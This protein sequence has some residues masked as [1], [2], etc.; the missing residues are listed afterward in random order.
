MTKARGRRRRTAEHDAVFG[1]RFF[2]EA[3]PAMV[4]SCP[5]PEGSDVACLLYLVDGAMLDVVQ[6]LALTERFCV[7]AVLEGEGDDGIERT[8]DDVGMAAVPYEIV[9]RASIRPL[10]RK[11]PFG[12]RLEETPPVEAV[13]AVE[14]V[15]ARAARKRK[16][17]A[18]RRGT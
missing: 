16:K 12:F 1:P 11:V 3:L 13:E 2:G 4:R 6:V 10:R 14:P 15:L 9:A 17:K 7:L 5:C 8:E 18:A